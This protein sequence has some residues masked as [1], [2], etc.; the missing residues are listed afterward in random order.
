M[1]VDQRVGTRELL[2]SIQEERARLEAT[3]AR[4][5]GEQILAPGADGPWSVKDILVH[6][7]YWERDLLRRLSGQPPT[8]APTDDVNERV[9]QANRAR[10]LEAV[11]AEFDA[12][13]RALLARLVELSD[14][15][16]NRPPFYRPW[17]A[18]PLWRDVASETYEH[19]WEHTEPLHFWLARAARGHHAA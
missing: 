6:I 11:M 16:L 7:S 18:R 19:Y 2:R 17:Q 9:F 5:T 12:S 1:L 10:P 14:E 15:E 8:D 3:L 4:R 13:Y